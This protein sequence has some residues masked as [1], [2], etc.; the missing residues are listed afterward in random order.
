ML[1]LTFETMIEREDDINHER[2]INNR[3]TTTE[4]EQ[5]EVNNSTLG[6]P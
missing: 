6:Y 5:D 1:I 3:M 2:L 4:Q